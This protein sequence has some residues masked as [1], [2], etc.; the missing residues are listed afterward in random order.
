MG[1]HT[2]GPWT[3]Q[4]AANYAGFAVF[5]R[6]TLPSLASVERPKGNPETCN[7][8]CHNFPGNTEANARLIAASPDLLD[9][10]QTARRAFA[11]L[12]GD[13]SRDVWERLYE[14][15]QSLDAAIAKASDPR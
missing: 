1:E 11:E 3:Y 14:V 2:K 15:T 5:P 10:C 8:E 6:G 7:I 13:V 9:A 4:P 12:N